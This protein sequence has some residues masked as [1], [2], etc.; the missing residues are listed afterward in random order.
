MFESLTESHYVE[1][2]EFEVVNLIVS[3]KL[4]L[5][6]GLVTKRGAEED[7]QDHF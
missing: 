3:Y 1:T 5:V 2:D 6:I 7:A 4:E